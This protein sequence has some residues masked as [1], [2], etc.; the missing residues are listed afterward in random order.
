MII[1]VMGVSGSGKSTLGHALAA[2]LGVHF[3]DGDDLHS[4][5]SRAKMASGKPL[6][7]EDRGPWLEVLAEKAATAAERGKDMVVAC[8]A[9][10]RTH[11]DRLR[12]AAPLRLVYLAGNP[13]TMRERL[14]SRSGHFMPAALI[15]SQ[16]EALEPPEADEVALT[17]EATRPVRELTETAAAWVGC[18]SR[19]SG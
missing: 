11:R 9:L 1:L 2:Q 12:Q 6:D 8:S 17:L 18:L 15:D 5:A 4:P 3:L 19:G 10:K 16:F 14:A 13:G 7:E